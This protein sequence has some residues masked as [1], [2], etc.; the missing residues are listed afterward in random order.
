M[1]TRTKGFTMVELAVS[2]AVA[3]VLFASLLTVLAPVYRTYQRTRAQADALLI[4]GNLIDSIR[5][6]AVTASELTAE[7]DMV[8]VGNRIAYSVE[9]GM[10]VCSIDG[11]P[12]KPVFD[13]KYYNGKRIALSATQEDENII[14]V[15][16]TVT[17]DNMPGASSTEIISPLRQV[18]S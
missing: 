16:V 1:N 8:K 5:T 9:N 10:L 15:T 4:A 12:A 3:G 14:A 17:G 13:E 6:T 2:F 7:T 18:L 11:K